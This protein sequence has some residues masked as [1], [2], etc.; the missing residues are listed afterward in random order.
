MEFVKRLSNVMMGISSME[1]DATMIVN[2][3][4]QMLLLGFVI[5]QW[6]LSQLAAQF[7]STQLQ[8]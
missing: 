5:I 7:L 2:W 3:R 6:I 1:M 8:D 4:I